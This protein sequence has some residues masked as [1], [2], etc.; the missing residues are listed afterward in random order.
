MKKLLFTIAI[1]LLLSVGVTEAQNTSALYLRGGYSW[2]TGVA[3]AEFQIGKV[4][5]GGGWMPTKTPLTKQNENAYG[6]CAT[7][8]SGN[9]NED[10]FYLS[11]GYIINGYRFEDTN[12]A[13]RTEGMF[14]LMGGYKIATE[15]LDLKVGAG[16]GF[17][18][19]KTVFTFEI[20]L[21]LNL[22][23]L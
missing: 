14:G 3:G 13:Y 11:A 10:A 1:L 20:T 22:L 15:S 4:G 9:Y 12:G 19:E 8:Y 21:G 16:A 17:H 2:F 23:G 5:F 7:L 6:M 18:S